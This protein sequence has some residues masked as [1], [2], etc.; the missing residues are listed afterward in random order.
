MGVGIQGMKILEAA[1]VGLGGLSLLQ[2]EGPR[3]EPAVT[4]CQATGP[5]E[6]DP[7]TVP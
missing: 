6:D 4:A 3:V 5:S 1:R 7:L 2:G